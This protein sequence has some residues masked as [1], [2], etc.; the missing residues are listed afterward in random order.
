MS[1]EI[2]K[3]ETSEE[4]DLGQLFKLIGK[5]FDRLFSFIGS[6]FNKLFLVFVWCIFF[7]KRH[8]IILSVATLIGFVYGYVKLKFSQPVYSTN[9]VIKQNYSTGEV[10]YNQLN[11][12]N[13]LISD[14]DTISLSTSLGVSPMEASQLIYFNLESVMNKNSKLKVFDN[15][16]KDIDTV[17]TNDLDFE[18]FLEN[19]SDYDYEFQRITVKS[20]NKSLPRKILPKVIETIE[21][22]EFYKNEKEKDLAELD[23][24]EEAIKQSLA[25]SE[26]LQKVYEEVLKREELDPSTQ[27]SILINNAEEK[28]ST[29]EFELF[30]NDIELR[31]ELV[32]IERRK[33]DK[34]KIV[35]II[36]SQQD[37]GIVENTVLVFDREINIKYFYAMVAFI[38]T[39]SALSVIT[40][41]KF[42]EKYK[43]Q[44]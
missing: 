29:K 18:T 9:A 39:F 30:K 23:L 2:Q 28:N 4:I 42:L 37:Q 15:F 43:D 10:I 22:I 33:K 27:T 13:D 41:L 35:E 14:N 34:Q 31:K 16:K 11:Y 44:V 12:Y 7:V 25:E 32:S 24:R 40:F 26:A 6:V 21:D 38:L 36:S 5:A 20:T 1:K 17:I 19:S 3:P 8:F